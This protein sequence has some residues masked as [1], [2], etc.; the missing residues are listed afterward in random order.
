MEIDTIIMQIFNGLSLSSILLIIGLGLSITFGIMGIINFAHGEFLMLGAYTSYITQNLLYKIIGGNYFLLAIP[1][2]FFIAGIIGLS[3]EKFFIRFLYGKP[4]ESILVTWGLS[5]IMQQLARNIFG[6][7][8]VDVTGPKW[9]SGGIKLT[10]N[11]Q[12][13]YNRI[14]I[15]II[16]IICILGMY[17]YLYKFA[18]G[19][20]MRAVMQNRNMSA[21]MGINTQ[22]IDSITFAIGCGLAG[23][24]GSIVSLLGSIGPSTGQNYIVDA[25]MVVV[26]GGV[27]NLSGTIAGAL[28]MGILS[29]F[30]EFITTSS[31]GKVIIFIIVI[32]FLQFKPSGLFSIKTR[33]LD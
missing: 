1:L 23:I 8:N 18:T 12:L 30:F 16:S 28:M 9:L 22:R 26:L 11:I 10:A 27:G 33:S 3:F 6:A 20:K 5:L 19:R 25:F 15:I 7:S 21:C 29:P 31:M 2:S 14:F 32:I 17:F 4:F 13:P 24:A